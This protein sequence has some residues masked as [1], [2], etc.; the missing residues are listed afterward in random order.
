MRPIKPMFENELETFASDI[1][2]QAI[3]CSAGEH[4]VRPYIG[5]ISVFV[6]R[7]NIRFAPTLLL[8]RSL[9][10]FFVRGEYKV[11]PTR[12]ITKYILLQQGRN[13]APV[14]AIKNHQ[15]KIAAKPRPPKVKTPCY[16]LSSLSGLIVSC[17]KMLIRS[18]TTDLLN[19]TL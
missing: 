7:A 1:G 17:Y 19:I 13:N 6:R 4:K 5:L 14:L 9:I 2:S 10:L 12:R 8:L 11:R 16:Y 15:C 18:I 3:F